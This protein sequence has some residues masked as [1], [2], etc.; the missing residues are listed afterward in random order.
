MKLVIAVAHDRDRSRITEGLLRNGFKFTK[1]G[2][3]GGFLREGNVTL[4]IGAEDKDVDKVL[5]IIGESCK[6]RKQ[7]VN[8][9]PPDAGPVGTII[10]SPVE[11]L[12]GGAITFVVDVERFE[13]F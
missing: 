10:P 7:F 3:T 4:L 9:L 12:V 2:S 8:V 5:G 1:I 13:R 11:V 6:T